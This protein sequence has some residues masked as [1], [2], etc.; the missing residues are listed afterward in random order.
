MGQDLSHAGTGRR[1][2]RGTAGQGGDRMKSNYFSR[3]LKAGAHGTFQPGTVTV[4]NVVH[5]DGCPLLRGG[6]C[7]CEPD[8]TATGDNGKHD[9]D[10]AGNPNRGGSA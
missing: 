2:K 3:L 1:D 7:N 5:D 8:I 9:I 10:M 4:I 6:A